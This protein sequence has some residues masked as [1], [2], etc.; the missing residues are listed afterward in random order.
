MPRAAVLQAL[1]LCVVHFLAA[2]EP[3]DLPVHAEQKSGRGLLGG[4]R[5]EHAGAAAV[6][7]ASLAGGAADIV[8][9]IFIFGMPVGDRRRANVGDVAIEFFK[10]FAEVVRLVDAGGAGGGELRG[11]GGDV[12]AE[13]AREEAADHVAGAV[14]AVRAVNADGEI[15]V[16]GPEGAA[17]G[18]E[19][20]E[21]V[22]C[23]DGAA[24]EK[25]KKLGKE[26][27]G[28]RHAPFAGDLDVLDVAALKDAAIIVA[29]RLGEVNDKAKATLEKCQRTELKGCGAH[30][31]RLDRHDGH[32][33]RPQLLKR[34]HRAVP[35]VQRNLERE[36]LYYAY[37]HSVHATHSQKGALPARTLNLLPD[38]RAVEPSRRR[39]HDDSTKLL[40]GQLLIAG[41]TMRCGAV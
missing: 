34:H 1:P 26:H 14:E 5:V 41:H 20:A 40:E 33:G 8:V 11:G 2:D 7:A 32:L 19:F 24:A 23:R 18:H 4:R 22:V 9:V 21:L 16:G 27:V 6:L 13:L 37:T 35:V 17:D 38:R 36:K 29:I 28:M 15:G 3:A 30:P 39:V 10:H 25:G 31:G 12:P